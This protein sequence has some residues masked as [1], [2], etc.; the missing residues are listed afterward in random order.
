[1][2]VVMQTIIK[3][4]LIFAIVAFSA[5]VLSFFVQSK[6]PSWTVTI[7]FWILML[8]LALWIFYL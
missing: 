7:A 5:W 4:V 6:P 8:I 3:S 2:F 1:M